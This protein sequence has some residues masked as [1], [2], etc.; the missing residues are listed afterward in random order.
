MTVSGR[1]KSAD[2][3][4]RSERG[5]SP[6][7]SACLPIKESGLNEESEQNPLEWQIRF[8]L[9]SFSTPPSLGG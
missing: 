1:Q 7:P 3:E 8:K 4:V 9:S 2:N 5:I 6:C